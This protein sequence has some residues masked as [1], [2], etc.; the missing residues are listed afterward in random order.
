MKAVL[1]KLA[2]TTVAFLIGVSQFAAPVARAGPFDATGE[3]G[4]VITKRDLND[5]TVVEH[6]GAQ[7]PLDLTFND[8]SGQP[9]RLRQYFGGKK[10]VVL[11]LGYYGCPMLCG[12]I[13]KGLVDA[14]KKVSLTAGKDYDL[15]FVSIDPKETPLLATQKKEAYLNE[16]GR[17]S[18]AGWHFLT[19]TQENIAAL[20]E[21][22]GFKYK[23]IPS[24]GQYAHP[25][26]LSLCMPDGRIS[27]YMY[28]VKFDPFTLRESLVEASNG[29]A[30]NAVD[31][32]YLTCF[33][34]DGTQGKYA[35]AAIN[36]MRA[37]GVLIMIV[38]GTILV[39]MF[40][41]E[42]RLLAEQQSR[43]GGR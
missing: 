42:R 13:S 14:V 6:T 3:G 27:R 35:F 11:Q 38:V 4:P 19:G 39:K 7:L 5:V 30:G 33:K 23:W 26:S 18:A 25:A 22:D 21:A 37:G 1:K 28:G 15:V 17:D 2:C 16:Y 34:Y 43:A 32:L 29:Q 8:E 20:A 24:A 36:L 10:P 9:V 31:Q 41:R 12:L 40:R